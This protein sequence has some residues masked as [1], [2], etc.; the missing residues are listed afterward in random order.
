MLEFINLVLLSSLQ[1]G[2]S[3][4]FRE[5]LRRQY[6]LN[7]GWVKWVIPLQLPWGVTSSKR[8]EAEKQPWG[9][10]RFFPLAHDECRDGTEKGKPSASFLLQANLAGRGAFRQQLLQDSPTNRADFYVLRCGLQCRSYALCS[11]CIPQISNIPTALPE[12]IIH[13]S[14][15]EQVCFQRR[16]FPWLQIL[17]MQQNGL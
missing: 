9:R 17:L 12:R 4:H 8:E 7:F 11:I 14:Q 10:A 1:K 15:S 6:S 16:I 13:F 5:F 3:C 2:R